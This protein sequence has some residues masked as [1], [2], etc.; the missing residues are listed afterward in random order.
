MFILTYKTEENK[1][2]YKINLIIQIIIVVITAWHIL[3]MFMLLG[4]HVILVFLSMS[5]DE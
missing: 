4:I 3:F 5:K 1:V 2:S